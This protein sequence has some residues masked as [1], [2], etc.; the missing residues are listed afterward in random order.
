MP[1]FDKLKSEMYELQ[2][3]VEDLN[4]INENYQ[5]S[6]G[7]LFMA[8]KAVE[9]QIESLL[10][11]IDKHIEVIK[12]GSDEDI[13]KITMD[14]PTEYRSWI[15]AIVDHVAKNRKAVAEARKFLAQYGQ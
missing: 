4:E 14:D 15:E 2:W 1:E 11:Q 3:N 8:S 5:R 10:D 6:C 7:S 12:Q 13:S 9:D